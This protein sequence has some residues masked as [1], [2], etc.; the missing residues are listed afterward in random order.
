M[1]VSRG[2]F[3]VVLY[4][5][6]GILTRRSL[7]YRRTRWWCHAG[8]DVPARPSSAAYSH[9]RSHSLGYRLYSDTNWC[10]LTPWEWEFSKT[11]SCRYA[12]DRPIAR[13]IQAEIE[14]TIGLL[15]NYLRQ[16]IANHGLVGTDICFLNQ[17]KSYKGFK[18]KQPFHFFQQVVW[19]VLTRQGK[20][21]DN[22]C[23]RHEIQAIRKN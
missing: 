16:A 21:E 22:T 17:T 23:A 13:D 20:R 7:Y 9:G 2:T 3:P 8:I 11:F 15:P 10:C 6:E 12:T 5:E 14:E 19:R 4:T 18:S 1:F